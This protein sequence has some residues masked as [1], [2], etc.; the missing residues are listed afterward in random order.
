MA[1]V[2]IGFN[3]ILLLE[4]KGAKNTNVANVYPLGFVGCLFCC[5]FFGGALV[6]GTQMPQEIT[7]I[8]QIFDAC[9]AAGGFFFAGVRCI[10]P[11]LQAVSPWLPSK[12]TPNRAQEEK[13]ITSK[14]CS[15]K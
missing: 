11:I 12:P 6:D 9:E 1:L 4:K 8:Q 13:I 5:C 10:V 15:S 3:S 14:H 7:R 2:W